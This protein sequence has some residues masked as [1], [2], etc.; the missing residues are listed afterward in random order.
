MRETHKKPKAS[1]VSERWGLPK[2]SGFL[3]IPHA[4]M[5]VARER[6]VS[7][8]DFCVLIAVLQAKTWGSGAMGALSVAAVAKVMQTTQRANVKRAMLRLSEK[9]LIRFF[10]EGNGKRP[11]VDVSPIISLSQRHVSGLPTALPNLSQRRTGDLSQRRTG[12]AQPRTGSPVSTAH[13]QPVPPQDQ[14][15]PLRVKSS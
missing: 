6:N 3:A 8:Y 7:A 12:F 15:C 9:G 2:G 11:T 13:R 4:A 14:E 1:S 5:Y 10:E